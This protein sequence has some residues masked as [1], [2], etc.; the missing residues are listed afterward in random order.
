MGLPIN[1]SLLIFASGLII[2][3]KSISVRLNFKAKT[4]VQP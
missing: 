4:N 2:E 3:A 1:N